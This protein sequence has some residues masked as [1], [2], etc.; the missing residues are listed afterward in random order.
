MKYVLISGAFGGMGLS[1][2]KLLAENG[3][4]VFALDKNIDESKAA[5]NIIPVKTDITDSEIGRAHV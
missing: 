4:T 2:A 5:D 3:Y 1:A